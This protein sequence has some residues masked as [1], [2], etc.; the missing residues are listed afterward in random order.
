[1]APIK[2]NMFSLMVLKRT[3]WNKMNPKVVIHSSGGAWR[4]LA[5]KTISKYG[6]EVECQQFIGKEPVNFLDPI[7]HHLIQM[8]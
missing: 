4:G 7:D 5:L 2:L 6:S 1:M 8:K 3:Q